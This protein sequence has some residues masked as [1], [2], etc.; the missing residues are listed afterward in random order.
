MLEL[1][2]GP[3]EREIRLCLQGYILIQQFGLG[4]RVGVETRLHQVLQPHY[5]AL[6]RASREGEIVFMT[7]VLN[8]IQILIEG[9]RRLRVVG[10]RIL[11]ELLPARRVL[12][13]GRKDTTGHP[14]LRAG[15]RRKGLRMLGVIRARFLVLDGE[16]RGTPGVT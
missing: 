4:L 3:T 16:G 2:D 9:E 10:P 6:G 11:Q 8:H 15:L 14:T 1:L 7:L 12:C 13:D 5:L